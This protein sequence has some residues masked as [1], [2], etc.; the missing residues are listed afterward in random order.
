MTIDDRKKVLKSA[1]TNSFVEDYSSYK[2]TIE[3]INS[4]L[5]K[6]NIDYQYSYDDFCIEFLNQT[7]KNIEEIDIFSFNEYDQFY[8]NF[9]QF[10]FYNLKCML[11]KKL[12]EFG[13]KYEDF[14]DK[15]SI[16]Q[17]INDKYKQ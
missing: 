15:S 13:Y 14:Y 5:A 16:K 11:T 8:V 6:S 10:N 2:N 4:D 12:D 3:F 17:K 9:W 7:L 1:L